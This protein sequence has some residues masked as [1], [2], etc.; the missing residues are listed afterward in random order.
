ML[1][2]TPEANLP[3]DPE[4]GRSLLLALQQGVPLVDDP[5]TELAHACDASPD[6]V[7]QQ[8]RA[9]E[10]GG[11]LREI[12]GVIEG[13]LLGFDS[14]LVAVTVPEER[15]AAVAAVTAACPT[16]THAYERRHPMNLWFTI[17]MPG[18]IG[19][20][21]ALARI[22][23]EAGLSSGACT[24]LRRTHTFKIGVRFDPESLENATRVEAGGGS[25]STVTVGETERAMIRALQR[26]LPY[27]ERPFAALAR[28][29]GVE[30]A[31]LLAFGQRHLGGLLRRYV[32][33]LRHR[34]LGVRGNGMVVWNVPEARIDE[35]G[36]L[37]AAAPEV[38]HCYARNDAPGFPYRVYSMIHARDEE[39]VSVITARLAAAVRPTD[40]AILF[41]AREF[42][43]ERLRY[44]TP[45]FTA[46]WGGV[47]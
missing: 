3:L 46:W 24:A 23:R 10:T 8:L 13:S 6:L 9:L 42:K 34:K 31:A 12:S 11:Q 47:R 4:R 44:F 33:T 21:A 40:H 30:E 27:V 28:T 35:V 1:D 43:K 25:T 26:P 5:W 22:E 17:A 36:A 2:S 16:V 20:D 7:L 41:S 37:L 15:L 19:V 45:E 29:T 18:A 32:A 14:A 39:A 38:S